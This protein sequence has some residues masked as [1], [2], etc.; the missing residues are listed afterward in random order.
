MPG[1]D[2]SPVADRK[3]DE[4]LCPNCLV[5]D[6]LFAQSVAEEASH[7]F[8]DGP[9]EIPS[10][11]IAETLAAPPRIWDER[12]GAWAELLPVAIWFVFLLIAVA[13]ET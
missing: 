3:D 12:V 1:T 5:G 4:A 11:R 10:A 13:I 6:V 2:P 9:G 8:G 7:G